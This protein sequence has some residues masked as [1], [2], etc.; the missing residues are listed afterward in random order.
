MTSELELAAAQRSYEQRQAA[1]ALLLQASERI[2]A[3]L[4]VEPDTERVRALIH[5]AAECV[6][7][8]EGL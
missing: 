8:A 7:V 6:R 1:R 3:A 2:M 5:A 4:V